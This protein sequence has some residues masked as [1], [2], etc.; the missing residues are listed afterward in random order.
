MTV[1][2]SVCVVYVQLPKNV[3]MDLD[4]LA[5]HMLNVIQLL[6]CF[7][8]RLTVS[9]VSQVAFVFCSD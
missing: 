1:F 5:Q 9:H 6:A 2:L 4:P 8:Q 3:S 7:L